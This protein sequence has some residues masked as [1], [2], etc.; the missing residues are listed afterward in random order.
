MRA[1]K[2]AVGNARERVFNTICRPHG[3]YLVMINELKTTCR[4]SI[5]VR[6][7]LVAQAHQFSSAAIAGD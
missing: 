3:L 6:S 1:A 7:A 2:L 5:N 4:I